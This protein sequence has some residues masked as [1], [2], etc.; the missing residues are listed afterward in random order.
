MQSSASVTA[1]PWC[2]SPIFWYRLGMKDIQRQD[3]RRNTA[4]EIVILGGSSEARDL[5]DRLG[6]AARLWLPARDRVTGQDATG[7]VTLAEMASGA[8]ALVIASHPCD[9]ATAA[10]GLRVARQAGVPHA[11]LVRPAWQPTRRDTWIPVRT[12]AD[13][14]AH[15][16]KGARVLVTLGRSVLPE[17]AALRH[18]FVYMRQ[19]TRHDAPFPLRHGRFLADDPP[20]DVRSEIALMRRFRIDAILTRNAGGPG[21]WPKIAAAR[22]LGIPVYMVARPAPVPGPVLRSVADAERWSEARIWLDA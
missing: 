16:P 6:D 22:A 12:V 13:A 10:L 7:D 19:L 21:G 9:G 2:F 5:A 11:S 15:I 18:A 8:A 14:A 20:F 3:L 1:R 4:G 17:L